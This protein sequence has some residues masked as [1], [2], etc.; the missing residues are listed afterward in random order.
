MWYAYSKA[1]FSA[2]SEW[3]QSK[4]YSIYFVNQKKII[5]AND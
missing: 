3:K 2:N 1:N 4:D 5:F